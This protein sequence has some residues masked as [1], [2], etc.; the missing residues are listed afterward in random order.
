M[1]NE[2]IFLNLARWKSIVENCLTTEF[3]LFAIS[4]SNSKVSKVLTDFF[5]LTDGN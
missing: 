5:V 3:L 4:I 1:M 2:L